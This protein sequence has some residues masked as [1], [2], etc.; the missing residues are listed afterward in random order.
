VN[1]RSYQPVKAILKKGLDRQTTD[2]DEPTTAIPSH[3]NVRGA[4]YYN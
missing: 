1:A 2:L 4:E 3:D